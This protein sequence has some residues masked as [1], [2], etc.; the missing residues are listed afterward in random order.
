M[1]TNIIE[2][3]K[4]Y[5][6]RFG[7]IGF[8]IPIIITLAIA[9]TSS[10]GIILTMGFLGLGIPFA[11]DDIGFQNAEIYIAL[12]PILWFFI[13][14]LIGWIYSLIKN[15][16]YKVVGISLIVVLIV[17]GI[18]F[19]VTKGSYDVN[20]ITKATETENIKICDKLGNQNVNKSYCY[21]EVGRVSKDYTVCEK[22]TDNDYK[23]LC[24]SAVAEALGECE[25]ITS[26]PDQ[27]YMLQSYTVRNM[28]RKSNC[29]V[30]NPREQI[31]CE[32]YI[33]KEIT[34]DDLC[35]KF[36]YNEE[37]EDSYR[38]QCL[39]WNPL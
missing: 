23:N 16:N 4:R 27:C 33:K 17:I 3:K 8:F 6:L 19:Y 20:P 18:G 29:S 28:A 31:L 30:G 39:S 12:V 25:K 13:G 11:L 22:S 5:C 35:G 14:A 36:E 10:L 37:G 24:T 38:S 26:S 7:I 1:E 9:G 21:T 32:Q 2:K 34:D 15:G